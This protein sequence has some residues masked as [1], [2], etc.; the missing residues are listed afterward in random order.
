MR[1]LNELQNKKEFLVRRSMEVLCEQLR[2][3]M[4]PAGDYD[5]VTVNF[6]FPGTDN[7]AQF[8]VEWHSKSEKILKLSTRVL[9]EGSDKCVSNYMEQGTLEEL[10]AYLGNKKN[11][12][13]LLQSFQHLSDSVDN[14]D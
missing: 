2:E 6:R 7:K 14:W 10:L 3:K 11:L 13:I 8:Y 4:G 5:S 9:P 1:H 12:P